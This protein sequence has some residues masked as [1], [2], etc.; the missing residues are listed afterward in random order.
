METIIDY[1]YASE[2]ARYRTPIKRYASYKYI[3]DKIRY[4]AVSFTIILLAYLF[5]KNNLS[6]MESGK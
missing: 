4:L 2:V 6:F 3:Y 5:V 1:L